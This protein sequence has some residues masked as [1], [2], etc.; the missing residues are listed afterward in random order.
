MKCNMCG[1]NNIKELGIVGNQPVSI[2]SEPKLCSL[3]AKIYCCQKCFHIQK[4]YSSTEN[5]FID[6]M[7]NQYDA[8]K[9][10]R[11]GEQL[12]FSEDGIPKTRSYFAIEKCIDLLPESG[13]LLDIGTGNGTA[14]KSAS[15]L[16][17]KW[18]LFG[19]D[20]HDKFK[21]DVLK[22]QGVVD[23]YAG[24]FQEIPKKKFDL[25]ILWHSLEHIAEPIKFLCQ[26]I[27]YLTEDGLLLIQVPNVETMPFD[28]AVLDHCS[29]FTKLGLLKLCESI[30]LVEIINGDNW[31]HNCITLLLKR[32]KSP[33]SIERYAE[34]KSLNP[35]C[36]FYWLQKTI[37]EFEYATKGRSYGIFG[38]G[39]SGIWISSQLSTPPA[40]FIDEDS[41]RIGSKISNV[42]I[43]R[44]QDVPAG[45]DIVMPFTHATGKNI[46]LKMQKLYDSC[47]SC[48]FILSQPYF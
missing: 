45:L 2:T 38:T 7:Y 46:T 42:P 26:V 28:L 5:F 37:E 31:V 36:Y 18:K 47:N 9:V 48:N 12:I 3:S 25:I 16:L 22:I 13:E 15:Q 40:F 8:Y 23:F 19:F 14:L 6:S 44:P 1:S 17:K 34:S 30:G 27:D 24:D 21:K 29:H 39:I 4:I 43:I 20:I 11:G 41:E 32:T 10:S 35:E 33:P